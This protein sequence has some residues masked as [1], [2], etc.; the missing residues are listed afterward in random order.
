MTSKK[1][2]DFLVERLTAWGVDVIYG[3]SGDGINGILGALGRAEN[4][5]RL[6]QPPHEELCALMATGH[7]KYTGKVGVCLVTQGPGAVHALNGLYDAKL[8]HQPVVAIL[9]Q[10][11]QT[12]SGSYYQQEIDLVSLFKDVAHEH[13]HVLSTPEQAHHLIDRAFRSALA[14]RT[15]TAIIVPHDVQNE[16]APPP[17]AKEHAHVASAIGYV[18]PRVVPRESELE[19]A[20]E[21]LNAGSKV[22]LLVGAGALGATDEVIQVAEKLDAG[23]AKA[24]LGKAAVPDDLPYVTGSV[25]WLGTR[26][27]NEMMKQCDTLLIV[28]SQFPY[29]EYLPKPGEARAVQ[30]DID[31]KALGGR[32][33][34]EVNLAGDAAEALRALLP[35]LRP[36]TTGRFQE[37]IRSLIRETCREQEELAMAD[38]H[39]L[40]P[41]RVFWELNRHLPDNL[42]IA[43]DCGTATFWYAK[44]LNL[45]RGMLASLSGTLATMG[46]ALPYALASKINYPHRPVL[47]LVGDGAMQMSGL[48]A[49]ITVA[50]HWK[51]WSDP[52]LVTVV[53]NNRQLS[54]VTWEQRAMEGDPKFSPSQDLMDFPFARYAELLGLDAVRVADP[55]ALQ[56]ACER[57][58]HAQRPLLIEAVTDPNVPPLPSELTSEQRAKLRQAFSLP[59][60]DLPAAMHQVEKTTNF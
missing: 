48:N 25:G 41:A 24:L 53:L 46:S 8:D 17:P 11:S 29:T 30:I 35:L 47:A 5:P 10:V 27:S 37:R 31:G 39:P 23:V 15:V 60:D 57:A 45:R 2:S 36:K 14:E 42:V 7:A 9:G 50:Q 51:S 49:L 22:A 56:Q 26:A 55:E 13:V 43:G 33:P 21:V 38:A 59:D 6:I 4:R 12:A 52:R 58:F 28:G 20:A 3:Y 1:V 40:N 18:A 44:Y 16:D 32:Y 54:Y 19:R 34:T